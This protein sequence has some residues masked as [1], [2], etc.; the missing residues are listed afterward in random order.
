MIGR[1]SPLTTYHLAVIQQMTGSRIVL[2]TQSFDSKNPIPP[3]LKIDMIRRAVPNAT[4]IGCKHVIDGLTQIGKLH[5][6]AQI[7]LHCGSDRSEDYQRLN[8]YT[9]TTGV[10]IK[11]VVTHRREA[12]QHSA[13]YVRSLAQAGDYQ[14]FESVCGLAVTDAEVAYHLIREN[15]SIQSKVGPQS[16]KHHD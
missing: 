15:A 4:I 12:D 9:E 10:T 2:V 16:I 1:F 13:S 6:N 11:T 3:S 8:T 14:R 7:T 5:T